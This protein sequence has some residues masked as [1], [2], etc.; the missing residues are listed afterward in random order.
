M[1]SPGLRSGTKACS[2]WTQKLFWPA[3][4]GMTS[5]PR[6]MALASSSS[7]STRMFAPPPRTAEMASPRASAPS[8]SAPTAAAGTS[9][10]V[11]RAARETHSLTMSCQRVAAPIAG[12]AS[13]PSAMSKKTVVAAA[14]GGSG[15]ASRDLS[16]GGG[17]A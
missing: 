9:P 1:I 15:R 13:D 11:A 5:A 14:A 12:R 8:A 4:P 6:E 10:R 3:T 2:G 16:G 17:S 7:P